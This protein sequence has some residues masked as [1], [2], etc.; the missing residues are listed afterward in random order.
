MMRQRIWKRALSLIRACSMSRCRNRICNNLFSLLK[1]LSL[2]LFVVVI[3]YLCCCYL[4]LSLLLFCCYH[5][6]YLLL[7][8]LLFC[9]YHYCYLLLS[10][11]LF[12]CYHCCYL[13]LSLLLFCCYHCCCYLFLSLL[14]LFVVITVV[15]VAMVCIFRLEWLE[16][17]S[18]GQNSELWLVDLGTRSVKIPTLILCLSLFPHTPHNFHPLLPN[19]DHIYTRE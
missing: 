19:L 14:L 16:R 1:L 5:Y 12:C 13:L 15:V 6:C 9:C 3:C 2:L 17:I 11:L 7:S 4:L 8:L 18:Q 10:L